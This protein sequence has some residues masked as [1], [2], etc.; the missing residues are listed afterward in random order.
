MHGR[1]CQR[2]MRLVAETLSV[3]PGAVQRSLQ[4]HMTAAHQ[5]LWSRQDK[6]APAPAPILEEVP[7]GSRVCLEYEHVSAWVPATVDSPGLLPDMSC[8]WACARG[9]KTADRGGSSDSASDSSERPSKHRQVRPTLLAPELTATLLHL[10][11][12]LQCYKCA[13]LK[14]ACMLD[15]VCSVVFLQVAYTI[16][17]TAALGRL[18]G[19]ERPRKAGWCT[20]CMACACCYCCCR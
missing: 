20:A 3:V 14:A 19:A 11:S 5:G 7:K 8:L 12:S 18:G 15:T 17:C 1:P 9:G 6:L 4:M 2:L 10:H 16:C 13:A